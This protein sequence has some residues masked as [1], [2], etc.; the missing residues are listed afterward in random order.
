M[1]N[2]SWEFHAA[3]ENYKRMKKA[4]LFIFVLLSTVA[5]SGQVDNYSL[6]LSSGGTVNYRNIAELDDLNNYTIQFWLN[7]D[8]WTSGATVFSRGS[9][10]S[11]VSVKL[12]GQNTLN[13]TAG[14]STVALTSNA[15]IPNAWN[16]ITLTYQQGEVEVF[17]NGASVLT[18]TINQTLPASPDDF[19]MGGDGFEGR[20]DEF[21]IWKVAIEDPFFHMWRNTVNKHHPYYQ[22]LVVYYKFDQNLCPNIV[23]Y[24]LKHHG[25]LTEN[26]VREL[27]SDNQHFKYR[28][29]VAYTEFHRWADRQIDHD[30]YL[31]SNDLIILSLYPDATGKMEVPFPDNQGTVTNGGHLE[32]YAGRD[33]VLSLNGDGAFMQ[34][35]SKVLNPEDQYTFSSWIYLEEWTE[36]AY[37]FKKEKSDTEGFSIR[38]GDEAK[39]R[40][41]VRVNG[42]DYSRINYMKVG[43]WIHLGVAAYST[44]KNQVF[45]TTFN[46][47]TY[48]AVNNN[49]EVNNYQ[50]SGLEDTPAYIGIN[51]NA[52]FDETVVWD[53]YRSGSEMGYAMTTTPMPSDKI[54]VNADVLHMFDSYW[55]YNN[56]DNVGYDSYSYKHFVSVLRDH[57]KGHRG[58]KIRAGIRNKNFNEWEAAFADPAFRS[59]FA[60]EVKKAAIEMDAYIDGFDLDF[61]WTYTN[62]GW[63]NYGKVIEAIRAELP[64]DKNLTVT[65]HYVSYWL[66]HQY[67]G[68]VDYFQFQIYGPNQ[69][70]FMWSTY[71]DALD[72]FKADDRFPNEKIILSYATITSNGF[73]PV[74][75]EKLGVPSI[76]VRKGLLDDGY[77]PEMDNVIDADGFRRYFTGYNQTIARCEFIHDN[78]L[79]GIMYWDMGNDVKTSHQYS[80]VKAASYSLHSN[81]DTLI[82]E[83][84]L[85][86]TALPEDKKA[87][88]TIKVYP[89]PA[90]Q[91]VSVEMPSGEEV[92]TVSI[93]NLTGKMVK[94]ELK[95]NQ[96]KVSDVKP[97]YYLMKVTSLLGNNYQAK[98]LV[99]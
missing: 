73:D 38:L 27:V 29:S 9:G 26:A 16:N 7:A 59:T 61:E 19:V 1:I 91:N 88:D 23:D 43:E 25:V 45:Q 14:E 53:G 89:N 35:G 34:V 21:R 71:Q 57:Y 86:P 68:L 72:R 37:I 20:I 31:L 69:N 33:G 36:G 22:D 46:G 65:P 50:L 5:I 66:P 4:L 67:V 3:I 8:V 85:L 54:K 98:I 55:H 63:E 78:D 76:G 96:I 95:T 48:Y 94:Q 40:I 24:K 75:N 12:G 39:K 56:A 60:S 13:F 32:S 62:V 18:E 79:G 83:V 41:Y 42:V 44:T 92:D 90:N 2:F 17:V 58:Y 49:Q 81:V 80:L 51:L 97:G 82:T 99:K 93:F 30:K 74:T 87:Y 52:K 70:M 77:S 10:N 28:L 15:L 47:V 11:Q 6:K 84:N 64:A